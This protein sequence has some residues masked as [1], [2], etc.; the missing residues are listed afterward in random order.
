MMSLMSMPQKINRCILQGLLLFLLIFLVFAELSRA[1]DRQFAGETRIRAQN[2]SYSHN[3]GIV[4]FSGNVHVLRPDMQIWSKKLTIYFIQNP[5]NQGEKTSSQS[6]G[7]A[8]VE[9]IVAQGEVRIEQ[10]E[11][12]AEC[13]TAEFKVQEEVL[14]LKGNPVLTEGKNKISGEIINLYLGE[15]KSEVIGGENEQ[16]EALFF[17]P[18]QENENSEP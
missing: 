17:T 10:E 9:K 16:V 8:E 15:N 12:V 5:E 1:Q 11:R 7:Q 6:F 4:E 3:Q 14:H 18:E 2:M 13:A